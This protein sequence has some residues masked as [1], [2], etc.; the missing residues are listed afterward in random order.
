VVL[1]LFF[2]IYRA[3][4][5]YFENYTNRFVEWVGKWMAYLPEIDAEIIFLTLLGFM[6]VVYVL[7]SQATER[8]MDTD[9]SAQEGLVRRRKR[10]PY[11]K[12]NALRDEWKVGIMLFALLNALLFIVNVLDIY[13]VW[14]NFTWNG[15]YL[16]Q[17]VHSGTYLLLLSIL[18]SMGLVLLFF[19]GNLNF[20]KYNKPLK[21]LAICWLAQNA[22]LTVSVGVRNLIYIEYF[23]LAY[24]RIGVL[25]FLAACLAGLWFVFVKVRSN[26]SAFYLMRWNSYVVYAL[27]LTMSLV[28]WDQVIA[29][30][31][32]RHAATSFTHFDFLAS[33]SDKTLPLLDK[34]LNEMEAIQRAQA[35]T[36]SDAYRYMSPEEYVSHVIR[37][38]KRFFQRYESRTWLSFNYA[39][40]VT[41]WQLRGADNKH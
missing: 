19:R 4:S 40:Y 10:R 11:I 37:R 15:E 17:F 27:L 20:Y 7:F 16:K 14:F 12:M 1:L 8:W 18:I 2:A 9:A 25:F 5:P 26:K 22:L 28:N 33:L 6:I 13:W 3:S 29:R 38:K 21:M 34:P 32:F 23:A 31:N 41:Y 36:I 35:E 39:E 30:Y 24:K